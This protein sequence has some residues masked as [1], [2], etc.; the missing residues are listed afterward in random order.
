MSEYGRSTTANATAAAIALG[1]RSGENNTNDA[2]P[3]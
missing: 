3:V 1:C 2:N